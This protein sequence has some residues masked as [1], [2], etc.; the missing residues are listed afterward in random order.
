MRPE[1]PGQLGE[2]FLAHVADVGEAFGVTGGQVPGELGLKAADRRVIG[3]PLSA[4]DDA[5]FARLTRP[6][7]RDGIGDP[8][9]HP[10]RVGL[11]HDAGAHLAAS[12]GPGALVAGADMA[13]HRGTSIP[14]S[15]AYAT[16][17]SISTT[18]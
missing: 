16:Y 10:L 4:G 17:A 9:R 8:V 5:S 7:E 13:G 6:Y 11:S 2:R 18:S 1:A 15:R 3:H 12:P 14:R